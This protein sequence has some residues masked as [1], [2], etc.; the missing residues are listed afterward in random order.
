L[1]EVI[2]SIAVTALAVGGMVSGYLF[3]VDRAEWSA[4]SAAA[5]ALTAQRI[6][7]T[8]AARWDTMAGIDEVVTTNFPVEV[9]P[10]NMP[11]TSMTGVLATNITTIALISEDPPLKIVRVDCLW[12][13]LSRGPFT[14]TLITYRSPDQ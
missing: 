12:S 8:R 4:R 2:I 10:L 5:Q 14:N 7:Q 6:E 1:T 3:S 11:S 9:V 13:F